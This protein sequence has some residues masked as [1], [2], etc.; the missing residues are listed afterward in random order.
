MTYT[1]TVVNSG[2]DLATDVCLVDTLPNGV[3]FIS[4]TPAQGSC[5]EVNSNVISCGLGNLAPVG[6]AM[7]KI[8]VVPL[9]SGTITNTVNVMSNLS[10]PDQANNVFSVATTIYEIGIF[11]PIIKR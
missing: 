5:L 11:L 6:Q 9:I 2:P 10:D 3:N 7:V 1:A 8:V 4:A